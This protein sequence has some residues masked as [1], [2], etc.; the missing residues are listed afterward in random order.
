VYFLLSVLLPVPQ[1]L[2]LLTL[3]TEYLLTWDWDRDQ[4]TT[5]NTVTFTAEYMGKYK[6]Q[7]KK[8]NWSR[9]CERTIHTHCNFTGSDLHYLGMY[10]LRVRASADGLNSD[11][12]LKDFCPDKDGEREEMGKTDFGTDLKTQTKER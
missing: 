7:R 4:M 6:M 2:T 3:N 9:V 5:G 1:N 8:K 10:V 12:V 11:W